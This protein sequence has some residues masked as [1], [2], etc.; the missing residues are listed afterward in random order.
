MK[1]L[2]SLLL[3][4]PALA[5]ARD[6]YADDPA[7]DSLQDTAREPFREKFS[8]DAAAAFLDRRAHLFEN[9]C[10]ACH[11][12]FTYLPARSLTNPLA[13]EVMRTRVMLERIMALLLDPTTAASVKTQHISR[14]RV[15]APLEL[16]RHDGATTGQLAP[17]T[18][19]GLDAMWKLQLPDGG[20]DWIRVK[21]APQAI[22]NWWPAAMIA[23]GVAA[24]PQDYATTGLA[25]T[26][27]ERLR[28][29]FRAQE[30]QTLHERG[31]TLLAH[32]AIQG[33][34]E[35]KVRDD[36]IEAILARQHEDG[37]WS[38]TDLAP[39]Q[40]KDKRA[41][42]PALTDGYATA[43]C[44]YVLARTG[45]APSEP[46]L[47]KA[48]DWLLT[49]QRLSGGWFTQSPF[50]RDKIASNTGTSF[51]IQAL[52]ACAILTPPKVTAEQFAA[53]QAK[54]D[55]EVPAGMYLPEP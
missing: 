14:I 43:F 48:V 6:P 26:G 2:L 20:I 9:K 54:A 39:W 15:L 45:I 42:D 12:T 38:M 18:R 21:E 50:S 4:V 22:D 11:S 37:G 23:V 47:K 55:A 28:G 3:L 32:S 5:L 40:R 49:H 34:L 17:L 35:E 51:A 44:A 33:I 30:P 10:Y 27:L 8:L 31:L 16:A 46:R 24:A 13:P 25:K 36:H 53:A 52:A 29:W 41:L 7:G 1:P 19:Q